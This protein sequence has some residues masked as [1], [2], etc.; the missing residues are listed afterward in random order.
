MSPLGRPRRSDALDADRPATLITAPHFA[1][2]R[3]R[4]A[5]E[6]ERGGEVRFDQDCN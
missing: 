2:Y 5:D 3:R 1:R 4:G 6:M